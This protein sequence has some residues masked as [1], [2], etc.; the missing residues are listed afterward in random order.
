MA[1][2]AR[3]SAR[4]ELYDHSTSKKS[5]AKAAPE[6]PAA[7]DA[8]A[9]PTEVAGKPLDTAGVLGRHGEERAAM[10]KRHEAERRDAHGAQPDQNPA[11]E[12]E[13]EAQHEGADAGGAD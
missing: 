8:G 12:K 4:D 10:F 2:A 13:P 1:Q 11:L 9:E 6:K 5:D 7:N 3:K